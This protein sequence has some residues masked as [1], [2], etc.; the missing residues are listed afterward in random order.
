LTPIS[1]VNKLDCVV[2]SFD[3]YYLMDLRATFRERFFELVDNHPEHPGPKFFMHLGQSRTN[4][5]SLK[6][7]E[8]GTLPNTEKLATYARCLGVTPDY[9]LGFDG[10]LRISRSQPALSEIQKQAERLLQ[11]VVRTAGNRLKS[12]DQLEMKDLLSWWRMNDGK[13]QNMERIQPHVDIIRRPDAHAK[14][15]HARQMGKHSLASK[16]LRAASPGALIDFLGS[17]TQKMREQIVY[18]Y[19]QVP[20]YN[21]DQ[22]VQVTEHTITVDVEA[23][24]EAFDLHYWKIMLPMVD[25]KGNEYILNY[26]TTID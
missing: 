6:N 9:L 5:Y 11:D 4:Y 26:S 13:L 1:C 16:S 24:G 25:A 12:Q 21:R 22:G 3:K 14:T 19:F 17:L 2:Q 15:L 23:T 8:T 10:D 18:S 20:G 7:P